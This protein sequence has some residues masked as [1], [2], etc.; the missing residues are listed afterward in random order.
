MG[1]RVV[2]LLL[3]LIAA[4]AQAG[5][6]R[7]KWLTR[8]H[9]VPEQELVTY[10]LHVP[11]HP[12]NRGLFVAAVAEDG[13]VSES[14]IQLDGEQAKTQFG[15]ALRLPAGPIVLVAVLFGKDGLEVARA[16]HPLDVQEAFPK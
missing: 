8:H 12:D 6:T 2:L 3:V 11:R 14:R 9:F 13:H 5:D 15:I 7:V 1:R 16:S 10:D 4:S